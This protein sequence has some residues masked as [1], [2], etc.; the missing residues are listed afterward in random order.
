MLVH[1]FAGCPASNVLA[2]VGL[3]LAD[4]FDRPLSHD[5]PPVRASKR[6][7]HGQAA[8]ALQ[9]LNHECRVAWCCAEQMAAGFALDP[10]ERARLKLA[11]TRVANAL[12]ATR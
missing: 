8:E 12:E 3:T 4:L 10:D 5:S 7:R 2:A 6:R 11:M 1:C 9:A